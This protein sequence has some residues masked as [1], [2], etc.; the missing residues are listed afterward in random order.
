MLRRGRR[1]CGSGSNLRLWYTFI[2]VCV[3]TCVYVCIYTYMH[4]NA[5]QI[6]RRLCGSGSSLRFWYT[7]ICSC[8]HLVCI[9]M[10]VFVYIRYAFICICIHLV[11]IF[12]DSC[13]FGT[14]L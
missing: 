4:I 12:N 7:F 5:Y 11:W 6:C 2:C 3:S 13:K 8:I 10:H 9:Y 1:L 14:H